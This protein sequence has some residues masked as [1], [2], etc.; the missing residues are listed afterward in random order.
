[1]V[2]ALSVYAPLCIKDNT[3]TIF[4]SAMASG[5]SPSKLTIKTREIGGVG[6]NVNVGENVAVAGGGVLLGTRV[7]VRGGAT[8]GGGG[9]ANDPHDCRKIIKRVNSQLRKM[10][11]RMFLQKEFFFQINGRSI[12]G[13][14]IE[15][16]Q[17][18]F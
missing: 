14:A 5:R 15:R 7:S 6:V 12:D 11:F 1:M 3:F 13:R 16:F 8:I 9:E 2:C 4:A 17:D 10:D 18:G